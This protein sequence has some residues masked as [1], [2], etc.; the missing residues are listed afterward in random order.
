M[1]G[2]VVGGIENE[3]FFSVRL[4]SCLHITQMNLPMSQRRSAIAW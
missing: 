1:L 2:V 3:V 4:S